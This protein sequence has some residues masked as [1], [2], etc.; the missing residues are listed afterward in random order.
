MHGYWTIGGRCINV[1]EALYLGTFTRAAGV[2]LGASLAM[3]WRPVAIMRSQ[4]R[5]KPH[6][7]DLLAL[8]RP[9]RAVAADVAPVP[10]RGRHRPRACS[11]DPRLFRGGFFLTGV[12]TLAIIAAVTHRRSWTGKVLGI[13]AA[14]LDRPAQ[15]R[16]CTC[17]TG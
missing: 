1:N 5:D 17:T 9:R 15:L 10:V 3:S 11:Y 16:R 2:L 14:A 12:C 6:R 7:L 4:L 13:A 8:A